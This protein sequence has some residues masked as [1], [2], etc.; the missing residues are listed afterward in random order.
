MTKYRERLW[1]HALEE[2]N[3]R[4]IAHSYSVP[5]TTV[6]RILKQATELN[7]QWPLDASKTKSI[8][9][10]ILFPASKKNASEKRHSD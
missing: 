7:L 1:L 3:Q 8:I 2:L 5:K 9:S 10:E 6:N 4:N